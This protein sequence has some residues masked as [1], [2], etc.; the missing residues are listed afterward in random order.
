M[1]PTAFSGLTDF[2]G[3]PRQQQISCS[4]N[5]VIKIK[6]QDFTAN[7]LKWDSCRKVEKY[8]INKRDWDQIIA[9]DKC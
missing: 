9:T 4:I 1:S 3:K 2:K 8:Q 6:R 5:K 7:I